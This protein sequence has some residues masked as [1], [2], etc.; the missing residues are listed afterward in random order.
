MADSPTNDRA[1]TRRARTDERLADAVSTQLD[2]HGYA[3]VTIEGV[4]AESGVAKTTIYR[5]W[6]SKA[7]MV[8]DLTIHRPDEGAL[9][10]TGTLAGDVRALAHRAVSF[11][12]GEPGLSILPG[13]LAEMAVDDVL[14]DRMRAVFVDGAR[15]DIAEVM[16]RASARGEVEANVDVSAFHAALL[17]IPYA[18]IHLLDGNDP[19]RLADQLASQLLALVTSSSG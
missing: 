19:M 4:A 1:T 18:R 3:G 2:R 9:I 10:D 16:A 7:E 11:I 5:R 17:G 6:R 14:A 15:K 13:L 8:F 12:G